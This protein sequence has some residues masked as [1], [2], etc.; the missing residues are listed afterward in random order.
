LDHHRHREIQR[1]LIFFLT[2][3]ELEEARESI[4][5]FYISKEV[6]KKKEIA[7]SQLTVT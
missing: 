3:K 4:Y 6:Q 5:L 1:V 2:R 7:K